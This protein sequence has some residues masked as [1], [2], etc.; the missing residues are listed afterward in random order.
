M[1]RLSVWMVR[2]SLVALVLGALAGGLLLGAAPL[3]TMP[4]LALRQM[5]LDLMLFGWLV[6]FV[7]GVAYWM[8]PRYLVQPERGP[9]H[10]A[11]G[12]FALFQGGLLIAVAGDASLAGGLAP[13]GRMLLSG[14][15]LVFLAILWGRARPLTR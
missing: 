12:A 8:L 4:G 3:V 13:A 11:W 7:L 14:A 6:Q 2:S 1:P 9:V 5:H 15:T 10:V